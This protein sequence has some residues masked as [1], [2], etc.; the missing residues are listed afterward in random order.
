M[1]SRR[2]ERRD[3][4]FLIDNQWDTA[5]NCS[6]EGHNSQYINVLWL[7]AFSFTTARH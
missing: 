5:A 3:V 2:L 7:Q 6:A 1:G 4:D